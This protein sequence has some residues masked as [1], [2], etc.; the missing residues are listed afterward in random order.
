MFC[1]PCSDLNTT[2]STNTSI[3]TL[4]IYCRVPGCKFPYNLN[5]TASE[6]QCPIC[7]QKGHGSREC[8]SNNCSNRL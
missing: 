3:N 4:I 7:K 2:A 8:K 1:F 6:H 5:H